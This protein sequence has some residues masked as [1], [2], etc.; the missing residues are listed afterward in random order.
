MVGSQD[1]VGAKA[2]SSR[3]A[4]G[5]P[6]H[7]IDSR[8]VREAD[9]RRMARI[10]W[11]ITGG[12]TLVTGIVLMFVMSTRNSGRPQSDPGWGG[13]LDE[14]LAEIRSVD[15]TNEDAIKSARDKITANS[16]LWRGSR[17]QEEVKTWLGRLNGA[18]P[19]IVKGR[20]LKKL[21][22]IE[23]HFGGAPI[24][25]LENDFK[26]VRDE[27]LKTQAT[28]AGGE[29]L[30]RYNRAAKEVTKRYIEALRK[31]A[32]AAASATT[33]EQLVPYGPLE[34][35]IHTL[36]D[37]AI[38]NKDAEAEA[39]YQQMCDETYTEINGIVAKLFDEAYQNKVPWS[40]LLADTS[41]WTIVPSSSFKRTF[42]TGLTLMKELGD[43]S[44]SGGLLYT[45][46]DK[47]RDYVL[48]V[49]FKLDSGALVFY[50]RIG[51]KMDPKEVPAFSVGTKNSTIQIEYGR[52]YTLVIS[53]IGNKLTVTG[54]GT[55]HSE[56]I[57]STKSRKG[58]PGIVA[59]AGTTATITRLRARHLR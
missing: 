7:V 13:G 52:T 58:E 1:T 19:I 31:A 37:E 18:R 54:E 59:E 4:H 49:E 6:H 43:Q 3:H 40:N 50:T 48:E 14:L 53:T 21:T 16:K 55:S 11:L 45:R 39:I 20:A 46:A 32:N 29:L 17:I 47:W 34:T 41:G 27:E 24:D 33:G 25:I 56:D 2:A 15:L 51:D 23:A 5:A 9:A 36:L 57:E 12:V 28:E 26:Y 38:A 8:R 44:E 30:E 35:T 42:G 10:G 22:A